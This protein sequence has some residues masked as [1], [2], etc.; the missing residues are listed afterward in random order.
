MTAAANV[1]TPAPV[2]G[3]AAVAD[4]L[5]RLLDRPEVPWRG[6]AHGAAFEAT[7]MIAD[8]GRRLVAHYGQDAA[9]AVPFRHF[10]LAIAFDRA[11][12]VALHDADR[13][14]DDGLRALAAVFGPVVLRNVVLPPGLRT[15]E[16]RNV[17]A[18]CEFHIDRGANQPDHYTLFWR[19][20]NDPTQ[21]EPRTSSTLVMANGAA[22]LQACREGQGGDGPKSR[23][24]LLQDTP[25]AAVAG[26]VL[27][28]IS[29]QAGVGVGEAAVLDNT[30]V[31]HASYYPLPDLRGYPIS[32]RYLA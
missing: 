1:E 31:L 23:Y 13:V 12:E 3:A 25:V 5:A 30:T 15:A 4:G 22:Y 16:Q 28:E 9:G 7:V 17:F 24:K 14:L 21:R 18:N 20:P 26:K 11:V 32:V 29:W 27:V 6:Q 10:G 19:D 2:L 8:H